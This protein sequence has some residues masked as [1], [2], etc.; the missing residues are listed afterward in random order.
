MLLKLMNQN[1][2]ENIA[3]N[4]Y[5]KEISSAGGIHMKAVSKKN[6]ISLASTE[7]ASIKHKRFF[8]AVG[9]RSSDDEMDAST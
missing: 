3:R 5:V 4:P 9:N 7:K 6:S 1:I 2:S 8:S